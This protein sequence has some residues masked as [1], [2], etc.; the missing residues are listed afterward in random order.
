MA[1]FLSLTA[2][3]G[4]PATADG[5]IRIVDVG[6]NPLAGAPPYQRL[7]DE[8]LARVVGFEPNP[9]ALAQL[10]AQAGS[11]ETYLPYAVGD[12]Q[13]HTLRLCQMSGMS[14]LL[15]PNFPLLNLLHYHGIW[16]EIKERVEL[17][18]RRLD[19]IAEIGRMD[20]LKIDIQGGE[21]SVFENGVE[22][23][24]DALVVHTEA[25]FVPMYVGQPLFSEQEMFLRR[26]GFM[27]HKFEPL[28]GHVL[29]PFMVHGDAHA[30]LSQIFWADV[31]FIRDITRLDELTPPQLLKM[32][33]ILNDIY[34]SYDVVHLVLAAHDRRTGTT[35]APRY[36]AEISS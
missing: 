25:M 7:L 15:E 34:R 30:P 23:L 16:A 19:D 32:A 8:K 4:L 28:V 3:L 2:Q 35:Y 17:S 27:T 9:D 13:T 24:K 10:H 22:R 26:H 36:L 1:A 5:E 11:Q 20:W 29:K 21:L 14:S 18:T 12:G 31:I 33:V 6:A